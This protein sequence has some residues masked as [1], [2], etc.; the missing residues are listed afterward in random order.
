MTNQSFVQLSFRTLLNM[1][2]HYLQD[3]LDTSK[4]QSQMK[5]PNFFQVN[6]HNTLIHNVTHTYHPGITEPVPQT[7]YFI[8][9]DDP[10]AH[11]PQFSLHQV[12]MTNSDIPNQTSPLYNVQPTSHTSEKLLNF[13]FFTIYF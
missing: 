2:S 11:P 7:N 10:T 13:S 12:Y 4:F 9:Y 3:I 1:L 8:H 5:N 6:D